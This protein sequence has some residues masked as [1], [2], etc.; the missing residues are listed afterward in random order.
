MFFLMA[1]PTQRDKIFLPIG[2]VFRQVNNM[3]YIQRDTT[4]STSLTTLIA[5]PNATRPFYP[6]GWIVPPSITSGP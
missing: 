3:V 2:T 1:K 5:H 4:L 6:V